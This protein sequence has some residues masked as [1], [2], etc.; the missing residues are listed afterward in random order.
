MRQCVARLCSIDSVTLCMF[1]DLSFSD[2]NLFTGF[3]FGTLFRIR[4]GTFQCA[5]ITP[6]SVNGYADVPVC[7]RDCFPIGSDSCRTDW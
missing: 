4:A 5:Y 6:V 2:L 3:Y 7:R 1:I